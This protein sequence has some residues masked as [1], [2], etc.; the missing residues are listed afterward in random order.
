MS[1]FPICWDAGGAPGS[2]A[3]VTGPS[4]GREQAG[5]NR[6]CRSMKRFRQLSM[7][8]AA[9]LLSGVAG[10]VT[11]QPAGAVEDPMCRTAPGS[12]PWYPGPSASATYDGT[13]HASV[14]IPA[15]LLS[16]RYVPQGLAY[17]NNWNGTTEDILLI[18]AYHDGNGNKTPDGP[19]AIFGVVLSGVN[20]GKSLGRMLIPTTH[21]GGIAIAGGYVYVGGEGLVR[22]WSAGSVRTV[23]KAAEQRPH[24]PA[25]EHPE[26]RRQRLVSRNP[27][28]HDLDRR[29]QFHHAPAHVAVPA[30]QQRFARLH[31][32][33]AVGT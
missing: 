31:R 14:A 10:V 3:V 9:L 22:Y 33:E 25:A 21:A 18:S 19:S 24:L 32:G 28:R 12:N 27:G 15:G 20:R 6:G 13:F 30:T 11:A 29:F 17:W 23:L 7:V 26:R 8:A 1:I 4:D 2:V 16:G 5:P